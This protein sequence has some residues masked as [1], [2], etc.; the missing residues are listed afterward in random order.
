MTQLTPS[1]LLELATLIDS[2]QALPAEK[3]E[4]WLASLPASRHWCRPYL[5]SLVDPALA[6]HAANFLHTL[7]KIESSE[8][9]TSA[10][11]ETGLMPG[12]EIGPYSLVRELGRG[13]MGTVWLAQ[14]NDLSMRRN[15]ALKLPHTHLPHRMLAERFER[16]R[17][18]LAGLNHP[19]IAQLYEAG[20]SAQ[21]QPFLALEFVEGEPLLGWCDRQRLDTRARLTLFLQ[22]L[23]AVQYAHGQLV[24]HR[25]LK[26]SNVLVSTQ[27]D[28]QL[29]DFGIAKLLIDGSTQETALTQLGGRAL[30]PQYASPEQISGSS[31]GTASDIYSLGVMLHELLTGVLPYKAQRDSRMALEDAIVNQEPVRASACTGST[32]AADARNTDVRQLTLTLRGDLDTI[33]LKTL[34]KNPGERYATVEALSAD[35]QRYLDGAPVLAQADSRAYRLRKFV[36]RNRIGVAAALAV[37]LALG[38]G[39]GVSLWQASIAREQALLAHDEARTSKAVHEFMTDIF[40]ANSSNQNDPQKARQTTAR[41]LLD[42]GA[43]KIDNSLNDAPEAHAAV[44]RIVSELYFELGLNERAAQLS[45]QRVALLRKMRGPDHPDVARELTELSKDLQSTNRSGERKAILRDALRI[46]ELHPGIDQLTLGHLLRQLALVEHDSR[47]PAAL[48]HASQA[49]AV[50]EQLPSRGDLFGALSVLGKVQATADDNAGAERTLLRAAEVAQT[51]PDAHRRQFILT[52]AYLGE[53]QLAQGK[54]AAAEQNYRKALELAI[55]LS[56]AEHIDTA[57]MEFRLG[58]LLFDSARTR[59]GLDLIESAHARVVRVRGANNATFLPNVLRAESSMQLELGRFERALTLA[60]HGLNLTRDA[61]DNRNIGRLLLLPVAIA[62][63]FGQAARARRALDELN[64]YLAGVKSVSAEES[65]MRRILEIRTLLLEGRVDQAQAQWDQAG[66]MRGTQR[67]SFADWNRYLQ[68]GEIALALGDLTLA[69]TIADGTLAVIAAAPDS[70]YL[71]LREQLALSL[72]GRTDLAQRR[73]TEAIP[74]LRRCIQLGRVHLDPQQSPGLA[75]ALGALS[76]A[77][78]QSGQSAD[79]AAAAKEAQSIR[80]RHPGF[81]RASPERR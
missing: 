28:V 48:E 54:V 80:A 45:D 15:V 60:E 57:Q 50:A 24:V 70:R 8:T 49:V 63:E 38:I 17:D 16:E 26:P 55:K 12:C 74:A 75:Q 81:A 27:G 10:A 5:A 39:L 4:G 30:T 23:S 32:V 42:I 21:G 61:K 68:W 6:Q 3:R 11:P 56:G 9:G 1:Q 25:D 79:A 19:H 58:Q 36:Q 47:D 67:D 53:A 2:L 31:I 73:F 59:E 69:S 52:L 62:V 78:R 18:I 22:V 76:E 41:E 20:F 29:L 46:L 33:V 43:A 66:T 51:A 37:V 71:A 34:K 35:L 72:K 64:Q 65:E 44:L 13:G 77:L 7:P 40:S 14:R